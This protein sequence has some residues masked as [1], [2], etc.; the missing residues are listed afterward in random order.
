MLRILAV[1][2][3]ADAAALTGRSPAQ[4]ADAGWNL[5]PLGSDLAGQ[6]FT[7]R[8]DPAR[9]WTA[10]EAAHLADAQ[11]GAA[12]CRRARPVRAAPER[13]WD[14]ARLR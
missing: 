10:A 1:R 14:S 13:P 9:C 12:R 5:D 4:W 2:D 7:A 6:P 11:I 3:A 8:A